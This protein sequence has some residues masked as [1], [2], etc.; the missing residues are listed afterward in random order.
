[1]KFVLKRYI[2]FIIF[3]FELFLCQPYLFSPFLNLAHADTDRDWVLAFSEFSLTG[4]NEL[5]TSY[6]TIVPQL[7]SYHL[8]SDI[9]YAVSVSEKKARALLALTQ[10]KLTLISDLHKLFQDL[11]KLFLEPISEK[12]KNKKRTQLEKSIQKKKDE[13]E[14]VGFDIKIE[15]LKVDTTKGTD[16]RLVKQWNS[17]QLFVQTDE[18][19]ASSLAKAGIS[20]LVRGNIKDVSGYAVIT[21][22]LE[23]GLGE[24]PE[25]TITEAGKYEQIDDIIKSIALLLSAQLQSLPERKILFD[26]QPPEAHIFVNGIQI[27]DTSTPFIVYA[28]SITVFAV[29]DG[30]ETATKTFS[31]GKQ[32]SYKLTIEL[33]KLETIPI[34]ISTDT[35]SDLFIQGRAQG[36]IPNTATES[37]SSGATKSASVELYKQKNIL[38]FETENGVHTFVV[39]DP[40]LNASLD[41]LSIKLNKQPIRTKI[42]RQ[43][44]IMYWSLA[45][46]YFSLP[47]TF[48]LTGIKNDRLAAYNTGRLPNTPENLQKIRSLN[49]SSGV[50][51]GISAGLAVNYFVQVILYLIQA[52][53]SIP[54]TVK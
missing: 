13:I 29:A 8:S 41:E 5:Y 30:F 45:A 43:R 7:L 47:I 34:T 35:T 32:N 48:I 39:F 46:V 6:S 51:I 20:A 3:F 31:F 27:E 19:L 54:R 44:S 37:D 15:T 12:E 4:V 17:G 18:S 28:P 49:I 40:S 50:M 14:K 33:R 21:V 23:T 24:S 25:I 42:E 52:D 9:G 38:D 16:T 22:T 53:A 36:D 11:D 26:V 1:M 10:K 2:V